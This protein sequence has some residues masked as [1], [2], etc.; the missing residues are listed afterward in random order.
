MSTAQNTH[1]MDENIHME[2]Q[3]KKNKN[4]MK[5]VMFV[6]AFSPLLLALSKGRQPP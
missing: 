2:L 4:P 6:L 5:Q 1:T 3:L